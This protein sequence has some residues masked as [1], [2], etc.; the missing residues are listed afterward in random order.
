MD[1]DNAELIASQA[2]RLQ[3]QNAA[4][5]KQRLEVKQLKHTQKTLEQTI[6]LYRTSIS[7]STFELETKRAARK[8]VAWYVV[9][10]VAFFSLRLA[11]SRG[12]V[13]LELLNWFALLCAARTIY[14][15]ANVGPMAFALVVC[16]GTIWWS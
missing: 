8:S 5:A 11:M 16:G 9:M 6:G 7:A 15:D 4:I 1:I 3:S 12:A 2:A 10:V 13:V 14:V